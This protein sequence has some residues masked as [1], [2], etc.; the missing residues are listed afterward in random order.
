MTGVDDYLPVMADCE[1]ALGRPDAALKLA[2]QARGLTLDPSLRAE[3]IIVEAGARSDLGQVAEALRILQ[4]GISASDRPDFPRQA[5][6]RLRFAYADALARNGSADLAREWFAAAAKFDH[7]Q[8]T[9]A[10][11]RLDELDGLVLEL[12][13]TDLDGGDDQQASDAPPGAGQSAPTG[14]TAGRPRS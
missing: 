3:M 4:A 9:D 5:A 10:Q 13:E 6:A 7:E 1:R 12:D 14:P 2:K 11:A 8:E